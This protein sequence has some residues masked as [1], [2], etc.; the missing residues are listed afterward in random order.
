MLKG[1]G[2]QVT[3]ANPRRVQLISQNESKTDQVDAELL[4][5]LG[6]VDVKLLRPIEHRSMEARSDLAVAKARD[7]L[8]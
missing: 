5:R 1:L 4:A 8:V 7:A 3:V 2:H 6:R